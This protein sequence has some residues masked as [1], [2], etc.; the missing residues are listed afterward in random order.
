VNAVASEVSV[1]GLDGRP[2]EIV[3]P[4]GQKAATGGHDKPKAESSGP[5]KKIDQGRLKVPLVMVGKGSHVLRAYIHI[6]RC[7]R[8]PR[9]PSE[10]RP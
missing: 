2:V 10:E 9:L 1:V 6:T 8:A 5:G 3:G 7:G 4:D